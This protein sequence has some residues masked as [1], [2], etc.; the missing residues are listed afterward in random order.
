VFALLGDET[1]AASERFRK[2]KQMHGE[3]LAAMA[4]GDLDTARARLE[5]CRS[6]G[7]TELAAL[8]ESYA[9]RIERST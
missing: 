3:L 1:V 9:P 5:A 7:G 4:S 8:L 6:L 2:L